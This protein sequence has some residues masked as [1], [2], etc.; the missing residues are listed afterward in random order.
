MAAQPTNVPDAP[1]VTHYMNVELSFKANAEGVVRSYMNGETLDYPFPNSVLG[2]PLV[3]LIRRIQRSK[4]IEI[5]TIV[6]PFSYTDSLTT[7]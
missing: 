5:F 6:F 7:A 3:R 1:N 4:N 2:N